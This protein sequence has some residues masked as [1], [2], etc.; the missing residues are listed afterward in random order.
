[1]ADRLTAL[2][3]SGPTIERVDPVR[4]ISNFSSGKQGYAIAEALAKA[5]VDVTLVTGPTHIPIPRSIKNIIKVESAEQM[6]DAC[7]SALPVDIAVCAAAVCDWRMEETANQKMKKYEEVDMMNLSLVKN[8]DILRTISEHEN[9]PK[10]V[11]GFAAETESVIENAQ[12]KLRNKH[13]DWIVANDVGGSNSPF[14][15]DTNRISLITKE[16][17]EEFE[18]MDKKD[19]ARELVIRILKEVA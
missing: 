17:I 4:F 15:A 16:K 8:P 1:M 13:C 11:V 19:V 6:L 10:L 7:L 18:E 9:R 2:V 12:T 3:T 14:G 5:K